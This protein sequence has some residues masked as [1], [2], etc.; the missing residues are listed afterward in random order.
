MFVVDVL[1]ELGPH[2]S[3]CT[4]SLP[5]PS[6]SPLPTTLTACSGTD[7]AAVKCVASSAY[8][9]TLIDNKVP[10]NPCNSIATWHSKAFSVP[11]EAPAP[12]KFCSLKRIRPHHIMV[13][14]MNRE[15][16]SRNDL[17]IDLTADGDAGPHAANPP[18]DGPRPRL[19]EQRTREKPSW[20]SQEGIQIVTLDDDDHPPIQNLPQQRP[21]PG[22]PASLPK[23]DIDSQ[24]DAASLPLA[25]LIGEGSRPT[26]STRER[27]DTTIVVRETNHRDTCENESGAPPTTS[28]RS[29]T[30]DPKR[31]GPIVPQFS[32]LASSAKG[33][34]HEQPARPALS[35][36][37]RK[38]APSVRGAMVGGTALFRPLTGSS[39]T[40]HRTV[41]RTEPDQTRARVE[42]LRKPSPAK[43]ATPER[44]VNTTQQNVEA[45]ERRA[46]PA[47][48]RVGERHGSTDAT[49]ESRS[50]LCPTPS[51]MLS[52]S[53]YSGTLKH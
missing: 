35:Q 23:A 40:E 14:A 16:G 27:D 31:T 43:K 5:H 12:C 45:G 50:P 24:P 9:S 8:P 38:S 44:T 19:K 28:D 18:A 36:A 33:S 46:M 21:E 10:S 13:D 47:P 53:D 30:M 22:K 34:K 37:I 29:K 49:R 3:R 48:E 20:L 39:R 42:T 15:M 7:E 51:T 4:S 11:W 25:S 32:P 2:S 41:S 1:M 26:S 52:V 17:P 6:G